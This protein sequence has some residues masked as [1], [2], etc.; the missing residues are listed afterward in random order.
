MGFEFMYMKHLYFLTGT[1]EKLSP[2]MS[3]VTLAKSVQ[4]SISIKF[5][6]ITRDQHS[7]IINIKTK[8]KLNSVA[9]SPQ[10]NYTDR[11]TAA[12]RRS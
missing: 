10:A 9:F 2:D 6:C 3:Y 8:T 12:C 4:I 7:N 1:A 5:L 11:V